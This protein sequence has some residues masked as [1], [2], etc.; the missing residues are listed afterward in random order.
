[1]TW[2]NKVAYDDMAQHVDS[3][4]SEN[5]KCNGTNLRIPTTENISD[6]A[7]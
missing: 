2:R 5:E 4:R 6:L 1:M 3:C 7:V